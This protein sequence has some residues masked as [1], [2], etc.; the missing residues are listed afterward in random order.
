MHE[1]GIMA[2][3]GADFVAR[4]GREAVRLAKQHLLRQQTTETI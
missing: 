4:D 1:P 3:C 2:E